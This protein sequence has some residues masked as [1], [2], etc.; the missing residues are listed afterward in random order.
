M[1]ADNSGWSTWCG[2]TYCDQLDETLLNASHKGKIYVYQQLS[3]PGSS[4]PAPEQ[5]DIVLQAGTYLIVETTDV[6]F[7]PYAGKPGLGFK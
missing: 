6:I 1:D 2:L 5:I 3:K 7:T 4:Y